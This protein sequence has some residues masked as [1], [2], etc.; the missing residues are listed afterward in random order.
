MS[1]REIIEERKRPRLPS[2]SRLL[3][4]S[5]IAPVAVHIFHLLLGPDTKQ[6]EN[7]EWK[8][9]KKGNG[10]TENTKNTRV[11]V[12]TMKNEAE[13]SATYGKHAARRKREC[14]CIGN[15]SRWILLFKLAPNEPNYL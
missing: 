13:Q 15:P 11:R 12:H 14:K 5:A 4:S 3:T 7:G 10:G 8:Q 6:R 2:N 9:K 1:A